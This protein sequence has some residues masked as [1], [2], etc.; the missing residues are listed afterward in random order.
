[1][2]LGDPDEFQKM[3]K[4]EGSVSIRA[5]ALFDFARFGL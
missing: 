5:T 3:S 4:R 2:G 1:M